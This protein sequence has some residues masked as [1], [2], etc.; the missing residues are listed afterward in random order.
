[1][2]SMRIASTIVLIV[3][4]S[5]SMSTF[6]VYPA[7]A[8]E[9]SWT[10]LVP[11]P[12]QYGTTKGAAVVDGKIYFFGDTLNW[13]YNPL[14]NNWTSIAPT[15]IYNS[16][17]A[18]V[19]YQNKIYLIGGDAGDPTQ[20]YDPAT[21]TWENRT[22][23]PSQ[24]SGLE[25]NVV[26]DKIYLI[27]GDLPGI[28][29]SV[30]PSNVTG[31]YDPATDSWSTMAPLPTPVTGYSSAVLDDKIYIIG[32]VA[33][34]NSGDPFKPIDKVQIFDP[35]T[36]QWTEGTPIPTGKFGARACATK[37]VEGSKRI[38]VMG[39]SPTAYWSVMYMFATNQNQVYDPMSDTWVNETSMLTRRSS[40][41]VV[42]VD[43]EI[44]AVGGRNDDG[45]VYALEKYTPAGYIPEFSSLVMLPLFLTVTLFTII[46]KR[47]LFHP[48]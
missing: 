2:L 22:S 30:T 16:G 24:R 6:L 39:G 33:S 12:T 9:G 44:Y 1:M 35:K 3:T 20:V 27:G 43:N 8:A 36:D 25:A 26:D 47:R 48:R 42:V 34:G 21:D 32:G 37:S 41:E 31:V 40:F 46:L 28:F 19:A 45:L 29:F 14:T 4:L 38:Y 18:V 17:A 5:F 15:P 10:T 7:N 11:L 23:V 13:R